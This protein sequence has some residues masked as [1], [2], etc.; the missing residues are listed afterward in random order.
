MHKK[1]RV[2]VVIPTFNRSTT[3]TRA[4]N[5]V[6]QQSVPAYEIIVV[7]NGSDDDTVEVINSE[8]P[9]VKI[10][11]EKKPGVSAARN[12]GIKA[13]TGNWVALLDSDD[14]WH[15]NKLELQIESQARCSNSV[16]I[17]HTD[18]VWKKNNSV[19]HQLK[20]HKK[21][22]GDIFLACLPLCCISPSSCFLRKDI[23]SDIGYFDEYLP[24]CEDYDFWLR[25]CSREPVHLIRE[26]LVIKH[27]GHRDQLS[28]KYWAMDR[29]RVYSL[30]KLIRYGE[31][32]L[33]NEKAVL[34]M[35]QSKID[36]LIKGGLNR[37]NMA[38][39]HFYTKK[40]KFWNRFTKIPSTSKVLKNVELREHFYN[41]FEK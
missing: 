39:V 4:L 34:E 28:Q 2:S 19:K 15:S 29:F 6:F 41:Y 18:E 14:E 35:L 17:I 13:S 21:S 16:R 3:I 5:S 11:H 27:G 7:D 31:L 10:L 23:F 38:L 9:S 32:S 30:E 22:G 33:K 8:Y 25:S 24:A 20:K 36:L 12:L 26:E 1:A 37:K 40:K